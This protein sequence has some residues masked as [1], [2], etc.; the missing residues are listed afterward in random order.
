MSY[1]NYLDLVFDWLASLSLLE[2]ACKSA[3]LVLSSGERFH[4]DLQYCLQY[5]LHGQLLK[6]LDGVY[7]PM[8]RW[9]LPIDILVFK[10]LQAMGLSMR[11]AR[12][13]FGGRR[14]RLLL[15]YKSYV[16]SVLVFSCTMSS[17]SPYGPRASRFTPFSWSATLCCHQCPLL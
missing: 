4:R 6:Y 2:N 3:T 16:M 11:C 7:G 8:P 9:N 15:V 13:C 10:G 14:I 17:R 5:I 12:R 1:Q